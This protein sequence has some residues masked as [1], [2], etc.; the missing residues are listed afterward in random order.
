MA[1]KK[2]TKPEQKSLIDFD[3]PPNT[4]LFMEDLRILSAAAVGVVIVRT[5]E[6]YRA[7][8]S[9][10]EFTVSKGNSKFEVWTVAEGWKPLSTSPRSSDPLSVTG[11]LNT[12][13]EE[14]NEY[15][16]DMFPVGVQADGESE[17]HGALIKLLKNVSELGDNGH[18]VYV[19]VAPEFYFDSPG[20]QEAIRMFVTKSYEID[21][22]L[23]L[24]C[25]DSV[26]V[27]ERMF[28][29]VRVIDFLPPSASELLGFLREAYSYVDLG[30]MQNDDDDEVT[31]SMSD[32]DERRVVQNALGMSYAEFS[33][34]VSVGLVKQDKALR[35]GDPVDVDALIST[36]LETKV[37]IVKKTKILEMMDPI[38]I[39]EVGGLDLLKEWIQERKLAFSPEAQAFGI[40]MPKGLLAAGVPGSG[41]SLIAKSIASVLS[42]PCISLDIGKVFGGL[43][44][45]SEGQMRS[46]LKT[47]EAMAPCVL[48]MDEIDKGFSNT[49]GGGD[50]GT[51]AR[52]FGTF[53]TWMQERKSQSRPVFVVMT[54]NNVEHLPPELLRKGRLDE[55]FAVSFP[56][57]EERAEILGIHFR[58]RGHELS[59]D[60]LRPVV[61]ATPNFVGA[62]LEGV[63]KDTLLKSF[64]AGKDAPDMEIAVQQAEIIRP[65]YKTFADKIRRMNQWA[66]N[67]AKP[68]SS[69]YDFSA[70]PKVSTDSTSRPAGPTARRAKRII[71]RPSQGN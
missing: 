18:G 47:V 27:P 23:I 26:E 6:L 53:L 29:D 59:A 2:H 40:D 37:E 13:T 10:Y 30:Q 3:A 45:Q 66:I 63:V 70:K 25:H 17:I 1:K 11:T 33:T 54:A 14:T 5:R 71:R 36:I 67:N 64:A 55:I 51:S 7:V 12:G 48:L 62:E 19:M 32:D 56:S 50:S 4:E 61:A 44:G 49:S 52:V 16:F 60:D 31:I 43:V 39:A 46:V 20:V 68:A 38:D 57:A 58:K 69:S 65:L 41:K 15:I 21:A 24:V 22:R 34:A 28:E 8:S 42:V 35:E 9:L